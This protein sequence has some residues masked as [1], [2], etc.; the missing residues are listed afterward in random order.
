MIG[1]SRNQAKFIFQAEGYFREAFLQ[2]VIGLHRIRT[3]QREV[4]GV[5]EVG[6]FLKFDS[7]DDLGNDEIQVHITLSMGMGAEIN[8][9]AIEVGREI[10]AMIE[11]DAAQE[12][13]IRLAGAAVL[14]GDH[15]RHDFYQLGNSG[16]RS[17]RKITVADDT[18]RG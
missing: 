15:A 1:I 9:H 13:L 14:R 18:L 6:A 2:R 16:Q 17:S 8:W 4:T 11:V 7:L 10:R 3:S 12:V 5:G